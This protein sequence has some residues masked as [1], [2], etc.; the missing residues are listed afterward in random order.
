MSFIA[1]W[2]RKEV[3]FC[4]RI[5]FDIARRRRRRHFQVST[6]FVVRNPFS[7]DFYRKMKKIRKIRY[8]LLF[9]LLLYKRLRKKQRFV[10]RFLDRSFQTIFSREKKRFRGFFFMCVY[11]LYLLCCFLLLSLDWFDFWQIWFVTSLQIFS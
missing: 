1:S 6:S 9:F 11:C 10:T 8:L 3:F 2:E 7:K 5:R 4:V